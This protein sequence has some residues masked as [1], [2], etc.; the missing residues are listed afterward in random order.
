MKKFLFLILLFSSLLSAQGVDLP[1]FVISGSEN[2]T[3][4]KIKK[5]KPKPVLPL[6]KSYFRHKFT[7]EDFSVSFIAEIDTNYILPIKRN[8]SFSQYVTLSAGLNYLPKAELFWGF[9]FNNGYLTIDFN[10]ENRLNY[11]PHSERTFMNGNVN[12]RLYTN[13]NSKKIPLSYFDIY[14][15]GLLNDYRFFAS[16]SPA[17]RR[18]YSFGKAGVKF[19]SFSKSNLNLAADISANDFRLLKENFV[20][21]NVDALFS[22]KKKFSIFSVLGNF[23]Y[24]NQK[25]KDNR[26]RKYNYFD[27][28]IAGELYPTEKFAI[29]VG[30]NFA[31]SGGRNFLAPYL[32]GKVLLIDN[33]VMTAGWSSS[34]KFI[35]NFDLIKLNPYYSRKQFNNIFQSVYNKIHLALYYSYLKYFDVSLLLGFK[36]TDGMVYFNYGSDNIHYIPITIDA[37]NGFFTNIKF[38]LYTGK[39]GFF[40]GEFNVDRE[41]NTENKLIPYHPVFNSKAVYN[42]RFDFGALVS[43]GV[44]FYSRSYTNLKNSSSIAPYINL[45]ASTDYK[46]ANNLKFILRLNNLLNR[47]NYYFTGYREPLMDVT[48][49]LEY[50]W[51]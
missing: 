22:A 5:A 9:P 45:F 20:E 49:G 43:L 30:A 33:L 3:L 23:H 51:R 46:I 32:F 1:D 37:V 11:L 36:Q 39:F 41:V 8:K 31:H 40:S 28:L 34:T 19:H 21:Q 25:L 6:G 15:N 29:R 18:K 14:A 17:V 27:F 24:I 35:S 2:V 13:H 26:Y 42:Y 12:L 47:E 10:G 50:F 44:N 7:P 16:V 4:P 48:A 38:N